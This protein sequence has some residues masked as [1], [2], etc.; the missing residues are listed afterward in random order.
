MSDNT[1]YAS[2]TVVAM[3]K[4][5]SAAGIGFEWLSLTC[6]PEDPLIMVF[7]YGDVPGMND[8]VITTLPGQIGSRF[9]RLSIVGDR[10]PEAEAWS[11]EFNAPLYEYNSY[12]PGSPG[13]AS[14]MRFISDK[15]R[16]DSYFN[17]TD[18]SL[19]DR[20]TTHL[21]DMLEEVSAFL[22]HLSEHNLPDP[23]TQTLYAMLVE[24]PAAHMESEAGAPG[25]A[26]PAAEM[27]EESKAPAAQ[28]VAPR[29]E[30]P[31]PAAE[32][33]ASAMG[34]SVAAAKPDAATT[35][36]AVALGW[37][38]PDDDISAL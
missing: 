26:A 35:E 11:D 23:T 12:I 29:A 37:A 1:N 33:L 19:C 17:Y 4:T 15:I 38:L 36:A 21:D 14:I 20:F 8:W 28:A 5:L 30:A 3:G 10:K 31:A 7:E 13:G 6:N 24:T 34:T 18:Q 27:L 32:A 2:E 16:C 9:C 22:D 25:T